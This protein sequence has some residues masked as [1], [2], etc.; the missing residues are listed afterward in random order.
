MK[1]S[2]RFRGV[3]AG[4]AIAAFASVW[5]IA[6]PASAT[7]QG[8][9]PSG[10][11][12]LSGLTAS[13]SYLAAR[14]AGQQRDAL[15]AAT[16]YRAALRRDPKNA[17]LLDRAFVSLLVG[18]DI[19][20]AVKFAERVAQSNKSD[21]VARLV[22]GV[23]EIKIGHFATARRN[24]GQSVRGPI[25]DLTATL[26]SAWSLAGSGDSKAAIAAIDRLTGPE[27]YGI[28][29]D[30][31]AGLILE[32]AGQKKEAGKR[33]ERAYKQDSSALRVV[34]AYG[35]WLSRNRSPQE[36]LEVYSEFDKVLPRHPLIVE[37]MTKLKANE[38]LP[39]LVT[40]P[41][42]GAA[43]ALYGLG[44]SLGRRG[45][46]DLG[47]VYL[48]LALHLAPN[49]ALALLSL[50]DLYEAMKKPE[51]A[52]K[53]YE[54]IPSNSVLYRNAAI[55]WAADLDALEK[56][57]EAQKR[58]EDLI[59]A[60]PKDLEATLALGNLLRGH[61]KFA[62]C[63]DAY[64]KAIDL[65]GKPEK[66]NWTV[67]YFR[68]I[69][70]ERAKQWP[71]AE[72]DL[73]KALELFPDQPHVLNYLGYSW[74]DQGVNLDEGMAMI[75]KAVAQRPDDGYIVDSLG[76]AHYRL[77]NYEEATKELERA[78]GLK[79]EDPTINDHLGDAYWRIGRKLEA[80]FQWNH[81]RDLKPDPDDLPKILEK[82]RTGLPDET[83][84]QANSTEK[85]AVKS[86]NGG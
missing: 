25:T 41:Q 2:C 20:E 16:Y 17:E 52:I 31:H 39:L 57:E 22:L 4:A 42:A 71:K 61:K 69:C 78:I 80:T 85:P 8:A 10:P 38:K 35:G 83:T 51:M 9:P 7:A 43:E 70:F 63:A 5:L 56:S 66:S 13:G 29:K 81:A 53:V 86:G 11:I 65:I 27:W 18:G 47:L 77:G 75:R 1:S 24:L 21:R 76:W 28:F 48:Q 54:R 79:P 6:A 68:G 14:H 67:F 82:L 84:S 64:S 34:E 3:A 58:L 32:S 12:D 74:I 59:K 23:H 26:L 50:A 72:A 19:G 33:F 46:E 30:L 55:Q 37:A 60:D 36:A 49:H 40:G 73:K 44:A 15:A 45:G 62:E